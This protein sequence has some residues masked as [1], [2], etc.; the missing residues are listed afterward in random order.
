MS[1]NA[2]FTGTNA[3]PVIAIVSSVVIFIAVTSIF[4]ILMCLCYRWAS[5]QGG[6]EYN[7]KELAIKISK[8]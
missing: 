7:Y 6:N 2:W 3:I 1:T 4:I 8:W 5:Q